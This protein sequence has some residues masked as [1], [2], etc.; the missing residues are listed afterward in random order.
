MYWS[1]TVWWC[2]SLIRELPPIAMTAVRPSIRFA[3]RLAHRQRHDGLLAMQ[4]VSLPS[5]RPRTT[6]FERHFHWHS[7]LIESG[8]WH[9][10]A[11]Q[12]RFQMADDLHGDASHV[13][14][15]FVRGPSV[16]GT[17]R[18]RRGLAD[19]RQERVRLKAALDHRA[20]LA[21]LLSY[22]RSQR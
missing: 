14:G 19:R 11:L 15:D 1:R 21:L 17:H 6:I 10:I 9:R 22:R 20:L 12:V 2:L 18:L 13:R 3:S 8:P 4:A 16:P 5:R 7:R